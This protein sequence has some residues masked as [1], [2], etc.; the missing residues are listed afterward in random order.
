MTDMSKLSDNKPILISALLILDS[1]HFVFARL[2]LP[3]IP[4][5]ASAMYV[6]SIATVVVGLFG[7][8][9]KRLHLNVLIQRFKTSG[10]S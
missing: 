4:P 2:L 10:F 8:I 6:M 3:H 7:L 5:M 9:R 1:L